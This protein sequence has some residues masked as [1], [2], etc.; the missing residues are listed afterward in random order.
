MSTMQAFR[1][2]RF[3]GPDVIQRDTI[4]VP[5]PK[6]DEVL[7]VV[8][9]A[10]LNPVDYKT[11]EGHYPLVRE[12]QLPYTLGRDFAGSV[13]TPGDAGGGLQAAEDVY[14]FIGQ[15]QGA[16]A[17]YVTIKRAWLAPMPASL[18]FRTA[19]A[20][21]LAGLTA[22]QGLFE[23]G[24][25]QAGQRVLIHAAAGGVGH[26][27]VQFAKAKGA[28]V[29]ATASGDGVAFVKAL[30][31]DVVIDHKLHDFASKVPQ[32]DMVFDLV[33][34]DTQERSWAI[35]K[36]G[37][38]LISTIAAPSSE[39]ARARDIRVARYTAHPDGEQL[40]QIGRLI[41]EERV[42]IRLAKT[43]PFAQAVQA[44]RELEAGHIRGKLVLDARMSA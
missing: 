15:E 13:V 20:V 28:V 1:I 21:P 33:G 3:G 11:R 34:G 44:E 42:K 5:T 37:G 38:A 32:V 30:G 9:A 31:A 19:A 24:G 7:V 40:T 14:A 26:L 10:S 4:E 6:N 17:E 12:S 35:L 8:R 36:D 25:V 2:H 18:D 27:A 41:D 39:R 23:R 43:F 16:F 22:W 29:Y